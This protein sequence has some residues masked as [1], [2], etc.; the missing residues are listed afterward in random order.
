MKK[1]CVEALAALARAEPSDIVAAAYGGQSPIF[2]PDYLIPRPFDPRLIV[3]LA[4]AVAKAAMDSGVA[5]R[6]I[7][8]FAAYRD[9]LSQFVFRTGLVMKP[10]FERARRDPQRV[11]YAEG[12]DER[13]LRAA[14]TVI[15][16][17]LARPILIGRRRVVESRLRKLGLRIRAGQEFDLVDPQ[18]D[19]RYDEY[20]GLYHR[21]MERRGVTPDHART[22]VRTRTTII[23]ALMV[24]QGHADAMLCGVSGRYD[25]H[26]QHVRDIIGLRRGVQAYSGLSVLVLPKGV[27]FICDTHVTAEPTAEGIAEMTVLAAEVVRQF[28]IQPKAA[29]L[30]HSSFGSADALSTRKMR[31]ALALTLAAD[32]DLEVE[33]EMQAELAIAPEMRQRMF[34]N[35]RLSGQANLLV[36]PTLDAAN[37]AFGLL[38]HLGEGMAIGP[39]LIG[40]AQPAHVLTPTVSVRGLVNMT[41]IAVAGAQA[42]AEK[43]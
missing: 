23:A 37:A 15:D 34:P 20:W 25:R 19:P 42:A 7:T 27:F 2:G 21:L 35:S 24:K 36:L 9:R 29:L 31:A 14:Q 1:A 11:V 10:L 39:I 13:V 5:T 12:E 17:K 41:A 4:P 18:S 6:P 38:R 30:S 43:K 3:E 32:P 28:G 26:L 22:L 40:A 33:G 16:E 8:D